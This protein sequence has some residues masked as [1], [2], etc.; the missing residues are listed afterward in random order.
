[1]HRPAVHVCDSADMSYSYRLKVMQHTG[2]SSYRE[3]FKVCFRYMTLQLYQGYKT[4]CSSLAPSIAALVQDKP[5]ALEPTASTSPLE[6]CCPKVNRREVQAWPAR[7]QL[8]M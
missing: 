1:M 6:K 8:G 7:G 5:M 2:L 4:Y 3:G